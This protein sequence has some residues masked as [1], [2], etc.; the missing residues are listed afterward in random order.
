MAQATASRPSDDRLLAAYAESPTPSSLE[1]L[2]E[3]YRPLAHALANRYRRRSEPLD[4]L[5]QVADLGLIKAIRGF[6]PTRQT[7]FAVYAVPTILGE[8]RR[9]FRDKV[10]NLRLPR[11]LQESSITV[12]QAIEHLSG[13][14]G[15][16][17]T[18]REL[19]GETGY[20]IED[21]NET[22]IARDAR[23]AESMDAPVRYD[24]ESP[25]TLV[26]TLGVI[27]SGYDRVEADYAASTVE[28]DEREW[29]VLRMRFQDEMSQREIG[30]KLG[31]SQ[32]QVSRVSRR[33]LAKLLAAVEGEQEAEHV[34]S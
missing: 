33:A 16:S 27:D 11:G 31:V 30:E 22:L 5:L 10:W 17:P 28:L 19:A 15:R 7:G 24:G 32:M 14:L 26:D 21:I 9:H 1:A 20:S 13:E 6:D 3:R 25:T 2:V 4:D 23:W 8:L 12:E 18:V 29:E 34:V